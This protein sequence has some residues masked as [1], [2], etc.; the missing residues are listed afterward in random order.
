MCA[1]DGYLPGMTNFS[2]RVAKCAIKTSTKDASTSR[3]KSRKTKLDIKNT[4]D[5]KVEKEVNIIEALI[6]YAEKDSGLRE[7]MGDD[8][9]RGHKQVCS[10]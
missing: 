9:A 1:N 2:C 8:F 7:A 4:V 5:A 3:E 6:G 10:L